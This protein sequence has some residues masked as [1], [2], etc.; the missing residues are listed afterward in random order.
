M[1]TKDR[2]AK[3]S[4]IQHTGPHKLSDASSRQIYIDCQWLQG[5]SAAAD[6]NPSNTAY[7]IYDFFF[8]SRRRHTRSLRD[9]SSDVLFRSMRS[10][11]RA[12]IAAGATNA[13]DVWAGTAPYAP[14][15]GRG[16]IGCGVGIEALASPI[17]ADAIM[18]PLI[19]RAGRTPKNAGSQSTRSASLPGSTEPIC[20]AMPWA[21][22]GQIV[23]LATYRLARLLSAGPSPGSAPRRAFI[24]CAVCQVRR[25][26]SPTRPIAWESEPIIEIAPRS[27]SR[28]SAAIVDGRIR[29][30]A[31]ARSSGTEEF[32]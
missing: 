17:C 23:Y 29:L 25:T 13:T 8:S 19:T 31:N 27:C 5:A 21:T 1:R 28:S 3:E 11:R 20:W 6:I 2:G 22:A 18:P 10:P 30:S 26:T 15:I 12:S 7:V 32:R 4:K 16:S 14:N 24:T 9:W